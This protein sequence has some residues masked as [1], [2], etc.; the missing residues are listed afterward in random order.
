MVMVVI[1]AKDEKMEEKGQGKVVEVTYGGLG[2]WRISYPTRGTFVFG[3]GDKCKFRLNDKY[4]LRALLQIIKQINAPEVNT[5]SYLDKGDKARPHKYRHRFAISDDEKIK[6]PGV[7][8]K[9][10]FSINDNYTE[11]EESAILTLC[12]DFFDIQK[13]R[14]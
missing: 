12:P 2:G 5:S 11:E 8:Q 14:R 13:K 10:S 4:E 6:I 9:Y 7:L 3:P 1:M